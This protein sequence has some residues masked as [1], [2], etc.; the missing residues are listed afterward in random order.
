MTVVSDHVQPSLLPPEAVHATLSVGVV[1]S[2]GHVQFQCELRN[3]TDGTL[4]ALWSR[5]HAER[6]ALRP[7][8][9]AALEVLLQQIDESVGPF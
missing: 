3:A 4:M 6:D 2:S 1:G 8:A 7:L 9:A 5:P